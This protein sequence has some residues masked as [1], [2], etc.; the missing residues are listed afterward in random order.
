MD[1]Q[2]VSVLKQRAVSRAH[3]EMRTCFVG[4]S[5]HPRNEDTHG[6]GFYS[7]YPYDYTVRQMACDFIYSIVFKFTQKE[8][9]MLS[10]HR[11][12]LVFFVAI[13]LLLSF[14][15][16]AGETR[17]NALWRVSTGNNSV[18]LLGSIHVLKGNDNILQG[19]MGKAFNDSK[20]LVFE[21][22]LKEMTSP[23]AQQTILAKGMLPPGESLEQK[24]NRET[25]ELAKAKTEEMGLDMATFSQF[26][27]W[28]FIMTVSMFKINKLGFSVQNGID[29][30]L[31]SKAMQSGK[32]VVG[33]ETFD[34]QLDMLNTMSRVN[35]DE[36]VRQALKDLDVLEQELDTILDAWSTGDMD[37]LEDTILKSFK[38]FP[39]IHEALIIERNKKWMKSIESFLGEK[40][41]H[42]VVVGAA[43]LAGKEGLVELLKK[44]GCSVEQL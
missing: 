31:Y 37:R 14:T 39:D 34:Q 29:S 13:A 1:F 38:E 30:L 23:D 42:M 41:N 8:N 10:L 6:K 44:K 17:H 26:K 4:V 3:G 15:V 33:L 36:L 18:Y 28:F 21:I 20:I 12:K 40:E 25:Y 19:P 24:I 9:V 22:D 11:A 35:Q 32:K 43:H 2:D 7:A 5:Y 27:P 16:N